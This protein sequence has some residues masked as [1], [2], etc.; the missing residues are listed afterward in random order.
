MKFKKKQTI[1]MQIADYICDKVISGDW[2]EGDKIPSVREFAADIEVNPNTIMRTYTFL[3]EAD[4]IFNR[5]GIG[6]FVTE[7]AAKAV[8]KKKKEDFIKQELPD[9][10]QKMQLLEIDI[11]DITK[12]YNQFKKS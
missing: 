8:K 10:F 4:I 12:K 9:L 3:Q 11:D 6:F 1:Y 5:R 7:G 2:K